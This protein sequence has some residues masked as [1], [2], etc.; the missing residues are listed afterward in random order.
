[1]RWPN[2]WRKSIREPKC[3]VRAAVSGRLGVE[4]SDKTTW[5][6]QIKGCFD[7]MS[8]SAAVHSEECTRQNTRCFLS[9]AECPVRARF[10]ILGFAFSL[11]M[12]YNSRNILHLYRQKTGDVWV[13]EMLDVLNTRGG[14]I[15]YIRHSSGKTDT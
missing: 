3:S 12:P 13:A 8:I 15:V 1:M 11:D 5:A 7:F 14:N 4:S 10:S 9:C 6:D 2:G